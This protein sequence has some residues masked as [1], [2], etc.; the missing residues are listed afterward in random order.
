MCK[1]WHV[2]GLKKTFVLTLWMAKDYGSYLT[3]PPNVLNLAAVSF[4]PNVREN[5]LP[6]SIHTL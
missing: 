4:L 6:P 2:G 3:P 5:V 1:T